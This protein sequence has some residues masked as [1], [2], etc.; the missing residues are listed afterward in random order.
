[1]VVTVAV[2]D[3]ASQLKVTIS[4]Q[5]QEHLRRGHRYL[6]YDTSRAP[7]RRTTRG[8][9]PWAAPATP[10]ATS[11]TEVRP[12]ARRRRPAPPRAPAPF[13]NCSRNPTFWGVLE[14][15]ETGKLQGDRYQ[16]RGCEATGV[17]GC[18]GTTN[19]E[20]G[21]KL[22]DHVDD[23]RSATP[24]SSR[25]SRPRSAPTVKLQVYDPIMLNAGQTLREPAAVQ[26]LRDAPATPT[27]GDEQRCQEPVQRR[28]GTRRRLRRRSA[29]V[30]AT[31][32]T[33][34]GPRPKHA[35]TT[36]FVLRQQVDSLDADGRA[37]AER[38]RRQPLHQAVRLDS[39]ARPTINANL[40]KSTGGSTYNAD[41]ARMFHNWVHLCTFTPTGPATTTCRSGPTCALGGSG[42]GLERSGNMAAA[43]PDRQHDRRARGRT[44]SRSG[45][46][47]RP[48]RRRRSPSPA[49]S[50]CRSS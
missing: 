34:R 2:G 42:T 1:M 27:V 14:G 37:G 15:P 39:H 29:P 26:Q 48:A 41:V 38:H 30:T 35:M 12:A 4:S 19:D 8:P 36:S 21:P 20:Y 22:S 44:P 13:P 32:A 45:P 28:H 31:R 5:D 25:S 9:R 47:P 16:T 33:G 40:F 50:T 24:S 11:R 7:P 3:L 23:E 43:R 46:S 10:S 17:D 6:E 49:T 18:T